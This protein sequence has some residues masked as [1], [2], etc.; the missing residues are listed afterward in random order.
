MKKVGII[1]DGAWGTALGLLLD[2]SGY[3]LSVWGYFPDYIDQLNQT[4]EN[5][6][7][8]PGLKIPESITF[9]SDMR[10]CADNCDLI[11]LAVPSHVMRNTC[12][13]LKSV[14]KKNKDYPFFLTVSKGI[15][16]NSLL[17]MSQIIGQ[18][19]DTANVAALS[20]PTHAE[21]VSR[22]IPSAAVV[23]GKNEYINNYVQ[24]LFST[25]F[26][27]V[28]TSE[29]IIGVELG[30]ALKNVIA[31]AAGISDGLGFGDNTKA[32]LITRGV[33][34]IT[35]L[36]VAM[37]ANPLTFAGLSGI[38]D[39]IVTCTSRHSR[40]RGLGEIIGKG[41]TLQEALEGM[42]KVAEGVK[43]VLSVKQL[44]VKYKVETPIAAKVYSV[45]YDSLNP[46][47]AFTDLMLRP[48]KQEINF[49]S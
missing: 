39:L 16:N 44:S 34:E 28:Y 7:F 46:F 24:K 33:A 25:D 35:R 37:G 13:T 40:N 45:L 6:K 31:V 1:G 10:V 36:G 43:T 29:D 11:L 3:K 14:L 15:E 5:I 22:C 4:R 23:G 42:E 2:R 30:G 20:G 17:R 9:T 27:R 49:I 32:A 19:L 41:K 48:L 47:D 8:L 38:G 26:F 21:E 12:R 18:E